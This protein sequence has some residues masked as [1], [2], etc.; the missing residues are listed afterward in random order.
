MWSAEAEE[1]AVIHKR[2]ALAAKVK[3]LLSWD[4]DCWLAGAE[5]SVVVKR[6]ASRRQNLLGLFIQGQHTEAVVQRMP[7]LNFMLTAQLGK[8]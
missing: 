2:A 6:P 5:K 8:V 1:L 4:N 3:P 7:R